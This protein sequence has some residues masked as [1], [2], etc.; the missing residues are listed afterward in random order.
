M[1]ESDTN[2]SLWEPRLRCPA[3]KADGMRTAES[4]FPGLAREQRRTETSITIASTVH[5]LT[6]QGEG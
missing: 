4:R 1:A 3:I 5:T 2:L 6:T